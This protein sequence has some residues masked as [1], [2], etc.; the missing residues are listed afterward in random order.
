M[1]G[2]QSS[3]NRREE[4]E[5][6]ERQRRAEQAEEERRSR[7]LAEQ[8]AV[9]QRRAAAAAAEAAAAE[10]RRAAAA[11]AEA[12]AAEKRRAAAAA[13]AVAQAQY[14]DGVSKTSSNSFYIQGTIMSDTTKGYV[15]NTKAIQT[16]IQTNHDE[17]VRLFNDAKTKRN[18]LSQWSDP[19]ELTKEYTDGLNNCVKKSNKILGSIN[20]IKRIISDSDWG[21]ITSANSDA[22][23][24]S[25]NARNAQSYST[26]TTA[27][28]TSN[29]DVT[30]ASNAKADIEKQIKNIDG[31]IGQSQAILDDAKL[32]YAKVA[33]IAGKPA[34]F[35][36]EETLTSCYDKNSL[37]AL[38]KS[39]IIGEKYVKQRNA[40]YP[41][42]G[43]KYNNVTKS[44][45][46]S[47][48]CVYGSTFI[49]DDTCSRTCGEPGILTG[50][51]ALI[52]GPDSCSSKCGTPGFIGD[53]SSKPTIKIPC[54]NNPVMP[55]PTPSTL[56]GFYPVSIMENFEGRS[57]LET[58][59]LIY[60]QGKSTAEN[61]GLNIGNYEA[62]LLKA[63]QEFNNEY[64]Y[65][66]NQCNNKPGITVPIG[67]NNPVN[68]AT[69][70]PMNCDDMLYQLRT[71]GTNLNG[72]IGGV[73]NV[74][75]PKELLKWTGIQKS[76]D[77]NE[78][79][80]RIINSHNTIIETRDILDSK[81]KELYDIPGSSISLDYRYNYDATIYSGIL[82]TVLASGLIYYTFTKL[83]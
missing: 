17:I 48:P 49:P 78:G 52:S 72:Y 75:D 39:T 81:L 38:H 32:L 66:V 59:G 61:A 20:S 62:N 5:R 18:T 63:L 56:G 33:E 1:G 44:C 22:Y 50:H 19:F 53:C 43:N 58:V 13:A 76:S 71:D 47:C 74:Q 54:N 65:Y 2:K 34:Q 12:A 28:S 51:Y 6:R 36:D 67:T 4:E 8:W 10:Q 70:L 3:D 69:N 60:Q 73:A 41:S 25:T 24:Q 21:Q 40:N 55:C 68:P 77:Y 23:T 45:D 37:C 31:Y 80:K 79:Y 46:Y 9:E 16:T 29:S 83:E 26:T 35:E 64:Y 15:D 14:L 42:A 7:E 30:T 57:N 27:V 82:L 11:A